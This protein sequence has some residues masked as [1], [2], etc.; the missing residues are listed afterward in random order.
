MKKKTIS[1]V[2][3]FAFVLPAQIMNADLTFSTPTNLGPTVNSSSYDYDSCISADGLLLL[4]GSS[5]TGGS[6][7][8]DL[9]MARRTTINDPWGESVNLSLTVNTPYDDT[10]PSLSTDGLSLFICSNRPGGFGGRDLWLTTRATIDSEWGTP[11]NLGS[12]IS[13]SYDE[14]DPCISADGLSLYFCDYGYPVTRPRPGG[15][16]GGDIWVTTWDSEADQWGSPVNLGT[17]I[18]TSF[19]EYG[20]SISADGLMLFLHSNRPGGSGDHDIWVAR[21]ARR[22]DPWEEPTNLGPNVNSP[23]NDMFPTISFDGRWLYFSDFIWTLPGSVRP[24]GLGRADIWKA[25]VIPIVDLNGDEIVDSVDMCI[26]VD[27]WGTDNSLCDI[28]PMPWGDGVVDV[29]DLVVLAEHLFEDHRL[30][31]HWELDEET[32]NIAYDS[33][34]EHDGT[35]HGEPLWQPTEGKIDGALQ[36]D[37]VDDYV[38]IPFVL[39]PTDGDFSVVAWLMGDVPGQ[40]VL[41]QVSQA[42]RGNWL[43]TDSVEG[44]LMTELEGSGRPSSGPLLSEAKITDGTWHRIGLVWD[45]SYRRLYVDG[46][47]VAK[48]AAPLSSLEDAYGGLYFGAGSDL[49]AGTFF[50]GLIDDVRIY[51]RVIE[52]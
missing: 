47:E 34:G 39:N 5:R 52:P 51:N 30:V 37:G 49:S 21:R 13:T 48:D 6:G 8:A 27:H 28:G 17:P 36:F 31:A 2:W 33:V 7:G 9:W 44:C 38:S 4:F 25:R 26:M 19:H 16:G 42:G 15:L 22:N 32:G 11:V 35:V 50:S 23:T 24:G 40:I 46:A 3:V 18:N 20:P 29:E 10:D 43:C 41:S 1:I 12:G 14:G 45:G